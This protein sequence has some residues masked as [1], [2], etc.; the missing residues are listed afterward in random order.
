MVVCYICGTAYQE[1]AKQCPI[2]GYVEKAQ[3]KAHTKA[4]QTSKGSS[5]TQTKGGKFLKAN[6]RKRN[7]EKQHNGQGASEAK[8]TNKRKSNVGSVVL[9]TLLLLA[10][11]SIAGYI[12]LRFFIPNDFLYEGLNNLTTPSAS[13]DPINMQT[14]ADTQNTTEATTPLLDCTAVF[15]QE[16]AIVLSSNGSTYELQVDLEPSNT[17]DILTFTSS[18]SAVASVSETGVITA[19]GEGTAVITVSCG[20]ASAECV[21]SCEY[22]EDVILTLNRKEITFNLAGQTWLVYSGS[23]PADEINWSSDDDSV[24][25]VA[26]GVITAVGEGST[27]IYATFEDQT[28]SCVIHCEFDDSELS[29]SG[30]ISEASGNEDETTAVDSGTYSLFNPYGYAEDVTIVPGETFILQ[31]VDEDKNPV[32]AEW[33][34]KNTGICVF[35]DNN[36]TAISSGYTTITATY[37]G[38]TYTC[39]VRVR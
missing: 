27:M 19:E 31:L 38:N 36:V 18:D 37:A 14:E 29:N 39:K 12:L 4:P 26:D 20:S 13:Q 17:T 22:E 10:I 5:H 34:V 32:E 23:V 3:K 2:C 28:L 8:Y 6:V 24:A 9:I 1:N 21:V 16:N 15:V 33:Q 7:L 11:L 30:E 35:K 25:T